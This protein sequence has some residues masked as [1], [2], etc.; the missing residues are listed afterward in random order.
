MRKISIVKKKLAVFL[1]GRTNKRS[2]EHTERWK[3]LTSQKKETFLA[4]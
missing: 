1:H 2:H 4:P 3:L